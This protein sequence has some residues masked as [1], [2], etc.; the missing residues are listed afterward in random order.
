MVN[1]AIDCIKSYFKIKFFLAVI[2]IFS[3]M[4]NAASKQKIPFMV[5]KQDKMISLISKIIQTKLPDFIDILYYDFKILNGD[6]KI[7]ESINKN[8]CVKLKSMQKDEDIKYKI[9]FINDINFDELKIDAD[10]IKNQDEEELVAFGKFL[11]K[12]AVLYGSITLIDN[13]YRKAW[14]SEKRK[15]IKKN[16][17]MIQGNF[18]STENNLPLLR[19]AYYFLND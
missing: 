15:F 8:I 6:Q 1:L 19:F 13:A 12:D 9:T 10:F 18:F 2:L 3:V 11:K 4:N 7:E 17:A 5:H 14:D 16:V